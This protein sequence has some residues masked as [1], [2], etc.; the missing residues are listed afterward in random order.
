MKNITKK[1]AFLLATLLMF[2]AF[3]CNSAFAAS[4]FFGHSAVATPSVEATCTVNGSYGG[5]YCSECNTVLEEATVVPAT[6]HAKS[7]APTVNP[8]TVDNDGAYVYS[9]INCN[10]TMDSVAIPKVD[11]VKLSTAKCTYNGKVRKPTVTAKDSAGKTLVENQDYT[12]TYASG[13]KNPGKYIVTVTFIGNYEGASELAFTILP[14]AVSDLKTTAQTSNSITLSWG[15]VTGATGYQVYKYNSSTKKYEK[16][17]SLT[18]NSYKAT[19]L[20]DN[21]TYKFKVR[22]YAKSTDGTTLYGE[23][24]SVYSAKTKVAYGVTFSGSSATIYV[25]ATKQLKATTNPAKRTLTWKSSDTS[26]AKVSSN[27]VVTAVKKGTVTITASFKAEGKTYKA[28]Y[29]ITVK[30]PSLKLDKTSAKIREGKTISISA[31]T[32]P[33]NLKVTW[34]SSN[35][36]VATVSSKGEVAAKKAGNTTI[37]ASF[38][39]KGKTYKKTCKIEVMAK[40]TEFGDITGNVT[41]YYNDYRGNVPDVGAMVILIPRNGQALALENTSSIN[42]FVYPTRSWNDEYGIYGAKVDG[43]GQYYISGVPAG[44]YALYI[45]SENTTDGTWFRDKDYYES[46]ITATARHNLSEN[47]SQ[48]LAKAIGYNKYDWQLVT[49]RDRFTTHASADFGITYI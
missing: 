21:A 20:K 22:A 48:S 26:I 15:K 37:T 36:S 7:D 33:E 23:Y 49:I 16:I 3:G 35:T 1:I 41:Y 43:T 19:G 30:T 28:T 6:G 18:T 29:K 17:K 8:A 32:A 39:Y 34:K 2:I 38:A 9:C 46:I 42:W 13:R 44:E 11:L 47:S 45:I 12:I 24:S 5:S 25:G 27:G 40:P 14:K 4:C 10:M 31:T